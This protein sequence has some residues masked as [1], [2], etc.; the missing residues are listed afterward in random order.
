TRTSVGKVNGTSV[1][2]RSFQ[3]TVQQAIENRQRQTGASLSLEEVD[4]VRNQ[5]WE[6]FIQQIIFRAEYRRYGLHTSSAEIAEAI[7]VSPP[8]EVMS[9][10]QFQSD[11]KFDLGKYQRWLSSGGGQQYIPILEEQYRE[12]LLR[13]KLLRRVISDVYVS[14]A[15]LWERF[16]D[17]KETVRVG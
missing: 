8:R 3:N 11:G 16:R 4:Q 15:A 5:V 13:G 6:Q 10:P 1:D 9:S 7:R 2:I 14:D 17:E 12:E